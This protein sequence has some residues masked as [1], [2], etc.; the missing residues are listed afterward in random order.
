MG[1]T[2]AITRIQPS[3][4]ERV[5]CRLLSRLHARRIAKQVRVARRR[6]LYARLRCETLDCEYRDA[7]R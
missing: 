2:E 7:R 3:I 1:H 4:G 6:E 5:L